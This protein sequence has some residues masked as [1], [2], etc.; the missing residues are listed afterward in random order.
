MATTNAKHAQDAMNQGTERAKDTASSLGEKAKDTAS[1]AIDKTREAVSNVADKARDAAKD[2]GKRAGD[3]ASDAANRLGEGM[4]SLGKT[5]REKGP[6][7]GMMGTATHRVAD[8]LEQA[9]HYIGQEGFSGM[10]KDLSD[11]IKKNPLPAVLIGIG[12]GFW[13]GMGMGRRS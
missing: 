12:L 13:L 1:S 8:T 7:E 5:V 2:A 11:V 9:G 10:T 4:E 3:L 6:R